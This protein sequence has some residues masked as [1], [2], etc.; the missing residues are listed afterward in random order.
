MTEVSDDAVKKLTNGELLATAEEAGFRFDVWSCPG[1][2]PGRT[3]EGLTLKQ[4]VYRGQK[5]SIRLVIV[6]ELARRLYVGGFREF[7]IL[8]A[9]ATR[10]VSTAGYDAA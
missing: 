4:P 5:K 10:Q 9:L 6:E 3:S 1:D 2:G 7:V 8:K